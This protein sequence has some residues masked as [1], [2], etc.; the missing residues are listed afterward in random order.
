M[1][2]V[3]VRSREDPQVNEALSETFHRQYLDYYRR[4]VIWAVVN[5]PSIRWFQNVFLRASLTFRGD[6]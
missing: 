3:I 6:A 5:D 1:V 2:R 4:L